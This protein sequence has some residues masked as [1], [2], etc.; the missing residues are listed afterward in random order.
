MIINI[1]IFA[2]GSGS[3]AENLIEK[4]K[5]HPFIRIKLIVT[6]NPTAGVI[7][8]AKRLKKTVHIISKK[9]LTNYTN[10]IIDFLKSEEINM[11]VLAGFL[12][13][14]PKELITAFPHHIINIHPALLPKYGGKGFYGSHVHQAVID[15]KESESGI[16][17]HYVNEEYDEG[18]IILQEKCSVTPTDTP[19]TL[20]NKIHELEYI[21]FPVAVEKIANKL[22]MEK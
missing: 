9:A 12:L 16:T 21:Y 17:I 7:E 3:N 14:V 18:Q 15:N 11:I 20:A 22:L 19:E 4:F 5:D 8:R 1:A 13:K 2:S 10:Q 6:N